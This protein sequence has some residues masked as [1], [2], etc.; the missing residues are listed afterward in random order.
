MKKKLVYFSSSET[1]EL[2]L[3]TLENDG[4]LIELYPTLLRN[5]E[6]YNKSIDDFSC[7][8][9]SFDSPWIAEFLTTEFQKTFRKKNL[10]EKKLKK[11]ALKYAK[12]IDRLV[13]FIYDQGEIK[14]TSREFWSLEELIYSLEEFAAH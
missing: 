1:S 9:V 10:S 7:F 3:K 14:E 12:K 8:S 5:S 13:S 6:N 4:I 11:Q 2:T